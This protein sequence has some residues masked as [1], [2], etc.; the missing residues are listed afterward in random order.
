VNHRFA[1]A[2]A[3]AL[4]AAGTLVQTVAAGPSVQL[5]PTGKAVWPNQELVAVLPSGQR[6]E[7]S[8]FNVRENGLPVLGPRV[9]PLSRTQRASGTILV[10]D[11]SNSMRGAPIR[12]A[13]DA[14]RTFAA[15]RN[16]DQSLG[17]LVFN[18]SNELL[19][20]LTRS[21]ARIK[22]SLQRQP[23][24]A[25]GTHLYDAAGQAISLVQAASLE[26]GAVVLLSDGADTGSSLGLDQVKKLAQEA[27]V[28]VLTVG[29]RS[30]TFRPAALQQLA[31]ATGGSFSLAANPTQLAGIFDQLGLKLANQYLVT[32]RS[33]VV[34]GERVRV[35]VSVAGIG[36]AQA[37]YAAPPPAVISLK[38]PL[39]NRIWRSWVT[40]LFICLLVAGLVGFGLFVALRPAGSTVRRRLSDFVTTAGQT[41]DNKGRKPLASRIFQNTEDSLERTPWWQALKEALELAEVKIPPVQLLVGTLVLT[42]FVMWVMATFVAGVLALLGLAVPFIVRGVIMYRIEKRR[43]AFGD[44]LPDNLD[45]VASGLRAGHSLVGGLSL[46][47][48]DA[49]E[50]SKSEFQRVVA[51]EQLGVPLEDALSVVARRMKSRDV[52]QVALVSSLQ[53]ETGSNSAEVLDR[54]IESIRERAALRRLVRGLTAQ[55]RLS[56]WVVTALP[57]GLLLVIS[58]I[59]PTYMKPLFTHTSGRVVLTIG[60]IM[61]IAGSLVIKKIVDIKV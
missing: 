22:G 21:Q 45:V 51:D 42:L 12:G 24:L 13:L 53:R 15:R 34:P 16:V 55:G 11:T 17:V 56:R 36:R 60:A 57:V 49:A 26:T 31:A 2:L 20:P 1:L 29:L 19:L 47:V 7:S 28:R 5:T 46:V 37:A 18:A 9:V 32:Y 10:I 25:Y 3:G 4:I 33:L 52:E 43:R 40:M 6:I 54:V 58:A 39:A 61:I 48:N 38:Q 8:R 59:N 30:R 41:Q 35:S 23:G 44:Q 50:P 27:H 14:A